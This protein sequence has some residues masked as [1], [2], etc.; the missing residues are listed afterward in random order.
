M[1]AAR[2]RRNQP[3]WF[4]ACAKTQDRRARAAEAL[5]LRSPRARWHAVCTFAGTEERLVKAYR[6]IL[7]AIDFSAGSRAALGAV[8]A[9]AKDGRL[10]VHLIHVLETVTFAVPR[11][12]ERE[13]EQKRRAEAEARLNELALGLGPRFPA[14]V[15]IRTSVV[16]GAPADGICR[17]AEAMRADLVVVGSHGRTGFRRALLGSVAERVARNAG[18]PILIVPIAGS[19]RRRR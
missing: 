14:G 3:P 9:V 6:R 5:R 12:V 11:A 18:R 2:A 16:T 4:P 13:Y 17:A 15:A 7:V 8:E 1:L 10:D 19:H